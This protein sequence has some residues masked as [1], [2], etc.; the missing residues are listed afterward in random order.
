[1]IVV[2]LWML[3]WD[4]DWTCDPDGSYTLYMI[5]LKIN[6]EG[7]VD[8]VLCVQPRVPMTDCKADV[9]LPKCD[10]CKTYWY[11]LF[12]DPFTG[13]FSTAS[14]CGTC[15]CA[16]EDYTDDCHICKMAPQTFTLALPPEDCPTGCND[17]EVDSS[18]IVFT[19]SNSMPRGSLGGGYLFTACPNYQAAI[20]LEAGA[21]GEWNVIAQ[22]NTAE[23]ISNW[24]LYDDENNLIYS[25]SELTGS[26][27]TKKPDSFLISILS[28]DDKCNKKIELVNGDDY[29]VPA[30]PAG[31]GATDAFP[32]LVAGVQAQGDLEVVLVVSDATDAEDGDL[33]S[34]VAWNSDIDGPLGTGTNISLALTA[35]QN[36]ITASVT[37]SANQTTTKSVTINVSVDSGTFPLA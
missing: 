4:F 28:T 3:G 30:N 17:G 26:G 16:K 12:V 11:A 34:A 37:D 7:A 20:I 27:T 31:G 36:T 18:T 35:G 8:D 15:D 22:L 21:P 9:V 2:V 33:T 5:G 10:C 14:Y 1:M 29:E 25:G 23:E 32:N 19:G 13:Y 24:E 6:E